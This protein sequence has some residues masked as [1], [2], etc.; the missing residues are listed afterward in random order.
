LAQKVIW[1]GHSY[2]S[3]TTCS[4]HVPFMEW[5]Q[6]KTSTCAAQKHI[7]TCYEPCRLNARYR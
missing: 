1:V 3:M 7:Y 6:I 2:S 5:L 4:N